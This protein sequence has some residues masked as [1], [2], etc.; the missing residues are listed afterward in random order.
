MQE[1][2]TEERKKEE[3]EMT[4]YQLKK[5][6]QRQEREEKER[7]EIEDEINSLLQT[8]EAIPPPR[9]YHDKYDN[10]V[11]DIWCPG[12]TIIA[13]SKELL[14]D[15]TVKFTRGRKYGLVGRN[16]TGKTTLINSICRK[17]ING[18]AK[19]LHI[20]QVEQEVIG[21]DK[22]ILEHVLEC[23]VERTELLT[24][25]DKLINYEGSDEE[26]KAENSQRLAEID[27]RLDF[28]DAHEA[29]QKAV[30]ILVGLG[31]T[32]ENIKQPSKAFSGG[33]RMRISIAKVVFC[34]PEILFLDEPTNHLD[35]VALIWL[36]QY[37][38]T[39]DITVV[40]I[41]HAR[42]FLN[43][44]VD[45]IIELQNQKLTYYKG[46]FD[47]FQRTK[48]EQKKENKI[49]LSGKNEKERNAAC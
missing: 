37:I 15:T 6:K 41:S 10:D 31:F 19:N 43:E 33:W 21:D 7:A 47:I 3:A 32:E 27:E 1:K 35:L 11:K 8:K 36:E 45:E 48:T 16:G 39:L 9:V 4:P 14:I 30:M 12:V 44:V 46:N 25:Q 22:S 23:D 18:L 2:S 28:I 26:V 29:E 24:E 40:I 49:F 38:K 5:L 34:E 20:L 42:D 17:E 13:G